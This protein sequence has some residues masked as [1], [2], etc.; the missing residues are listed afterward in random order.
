MAIFAENCVQ[1]HG[2]HATG[3]DAGPPLVHKIYEPSHHGD[4]AFYAAVRQGVHQHHWPFGSMPAIPGVTEDQVTLII[5]YVR[6]L[7]R[8]NGIN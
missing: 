6:T 7:Q 1:C 2:Q 3:T 4:G 5:A 8:A